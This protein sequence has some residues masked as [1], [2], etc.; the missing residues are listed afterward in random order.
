MAFPIS[1]N[2]RCGH[3]ILAHFRPNI[4]DCTKCDGKCLR[5]GFWHSNKIL[6][7][8]MGICEDEA[9]TRVRENKVVY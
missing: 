9:Y 3:D 7:A 1:D 2:C 8:F 4:D 6:N 5:F